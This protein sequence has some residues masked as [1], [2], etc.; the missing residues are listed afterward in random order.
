MKLNPLSESVH[1]IVKA[2]VIAG[3]VYGIARLLPVE[4]VTSSVTANVL[5]RL[6][7]PAVSY[8]Q[9]GRVYLGYL[10]ISIDCTALEVVAIFL[11][12]ILAAKTNW[13]KKLIFSVF[14]SV[15]VCVANI[16]RI[17]MV[18]YFLEHDIPWYIAHDI[19][20]GGLA[21]VSGMLFLVVSERYMPQINQNLYTLLER[22][23][24][25]LPRIR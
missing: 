10:Y 11:G 15:T 21:I 2:A 20:S 8:E 14:V 25:A 12:L 7:V 5:T 13:V 16:A 19:F 9:Y 23:E 22:I 18:Y 3:V 4:E 17:S 6:G 24:C 1:Y